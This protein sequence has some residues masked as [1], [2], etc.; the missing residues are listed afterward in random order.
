MSRI[1]LATFA[2]GV[3]KAVDCL[4]RQMVNWVIESSRNGVAI[5]L[6]GGLDSSAVV[7]LCRFAFMGYQYKVDGLVMPS[8]VNVG[9]DAVDAVEVAKLLNVPIEYLPL[10]DVAESIFTLMPALREDAAERGNM[11]SELRALLLSRYGARHN[12]LFAGTGNFDEDF[13]TGYFTKRG[14]GAADNNIFG[15]LPKH[16]VR[17][18]LSFLAEKLGTL[19]VVER[20]LTKPPSAGLEVGQTDEKDL[21]YDWF[22]AN[23]AWRAIELDGHAFSNGK[24]A[25]VY[26]EEMGIDL[27]MAR[28]II[29]DVMARHESTG[30]KRELPD[31]GQVDLTYN[32]ELQ[33]VT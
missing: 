8:S 27:N 19:S 20:I 24:V 5:G 18:V 9:Q 12:L 6:S 23:A 14:D 1:K 26:A 10:D 33:V 11:Y 29:H 2:H 3:D 31:I 16:L 7:H 4:A 28:S 25:E 17:E 15:N 13:I 30:H 22:A 32:L 21:G